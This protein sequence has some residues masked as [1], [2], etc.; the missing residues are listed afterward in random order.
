MLHITAQHPGRVDGDKG[1]VPVNLHPQS[2]SSVCYLRSN[3]AQ[4][5]DAQLFP[6]NLMTGKSLLAL[7]RRLCDV[8]ILRILP[9]PLDSAHHVTGGQEQARQHQLLHAVGIGSRSVEHHHA[10]LG[11]GIQGNIVHPGSGP[12]YRQEALRQLH[13][14]HGG[15]AHQNAV[16][17]IDIVRYL[18]ILRQA[19]QTALCNRI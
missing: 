7:F 14:V 19:V 13:L 8:G 10:G 11:T 5:D 4:S 16:G 3:G 6:E 17:L 2:R 1:V 12:G 18:I 15:A 9:A